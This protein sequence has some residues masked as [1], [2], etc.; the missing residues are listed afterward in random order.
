MDTLGTR[1]KRTRERAGLTA[2][3]LSQLAGLKNASHV[4]MIER[5]ARPGISA[6]TAVGLAQALGCSVAWLVLGV[7]NEPDNDTICTSVK[8]AREASRGKAAA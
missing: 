6:T 7:G 5:G 2:T 3:E 1:L 8:R 4:G